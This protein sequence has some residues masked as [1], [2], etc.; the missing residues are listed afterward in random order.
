MKLCIVLILLVGRLDEIANG[1]RRNPLPSGVLRGSGI[2][3]DASGIQWKQQ[4][5]R[6]SRVGFSWPLSIHVLAIRPSF[7][8]IP[9]SAVSAIYFVAG[10]LAHAMCSRIADHARPAKPA[11]DAW[12]FEGAASTATRPTAHGRGTR[13]T[14]NDRTLSPISGPATQSLTLCIRCESLSRRGH[15]AGQRFGFG[16]LENHAAIIQRDGRPTPSLLCR[17]FV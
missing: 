9:S 3:A 7:F 11:I 10:A 16:R 6:L 1:L 12:L 14:Q 5:N 13:A 17:R 8:L 2:A 4:L 15:H